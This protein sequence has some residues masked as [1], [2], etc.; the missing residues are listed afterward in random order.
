LRFAKYLPLVWGADNLISHKS[1][2]FR[3]S[4]K[5][6]INYQEEYYS[7][8]SSI[9]LFQVA[10]GILLFT[11]PIYSQITPAQLEIGLNFS[12]NSGATF[13]NVLAFGLDPAAT[14]GYDGLPFEDALPPFAPALEV[15]FVIGAFESYTDIR[16][17]PSFPFSGV[18][19]LDL[20][21]QL[22]TG[23]S[24]NVLTIN[25]NL[26]SG[27][28]IVVSTLLG[29]SP[30]LSGSGSYNITNANVLTQGKLIVTYDNVTDVQD[31][32]QNPINF[33]LNQNYPNPFNP[34]TTINVTLPVGSEITLKVFDLLGN[35][36][37]EIATGYYNSGNYNFN[38]DG[39]NL[40][41]GI[42]I[43]QLKHEQGIISKKMTLLK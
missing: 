2:N 5:I 33:E 36:V 26:P 39:K 11:I 32:I 37:S 10:F 14:S 1:N 8:K 19:T 15:R 43:Y 22:Q 42:Y 41:S 16:H 18:D 25:Y 28:S 13:N 7:M 23:T 35:E 4:F 12:D 40:A 6:L 38:F 27:V 20:K 30:L 17:A 21:W 34:G 9:K 3:I 29:S 24:A 31:I